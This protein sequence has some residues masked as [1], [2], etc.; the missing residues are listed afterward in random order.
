MQLDLPHWSAPCKVI[1]FPAD[2]RKGHAFKVAH[3]LSKARTNKE[4]DWILTRALVSYHD[5]LIRAGLSASVASRQTEVFKRLIF[6]RCEVIDSRWRPTIDIP[7]HG[8]GAA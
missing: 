8:G 7:E 3:Q 5:H 1:A 2:K 6:E 4:A